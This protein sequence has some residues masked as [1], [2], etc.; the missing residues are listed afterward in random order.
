[1]K[2]SCGCEMYLRLDTEGKYFWAC[3]DMP[4]CFEFKD[5]VPPKR[6]FDYSMAAPNDIQD[7]LL[8]Y[9]EGSITEQKNEIKVQMVEILE[10]YIECQYG[11]HYA[12]MLEEILIPYLED[13]AALDFVLKGHS[14]K[15]GKG[16]VQIGKT[17]AKIYPELM[18]CLRR[19]HSKKIQNYL[20][21][22]FG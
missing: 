14:V 17:G 15:D 1:M 3:S 16:N 4:E 10:H 6:R 9:H 5:Y 11:P 8:N 20:N 21:I 13:P 18:D 2:C 22:E 19:V 12:F 7:A